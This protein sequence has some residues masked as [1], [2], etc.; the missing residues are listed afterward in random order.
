MRVSL[1]L[2]LLLGTHSIWALFS[3]P[4]QICY[5]WCV[6]VVIHSA[7]SNQYG[8]KSACFC[9][10][11]FHLFSSHLIFALSFAWFCS[12]FLCALDFLFCVTYAC[13]YACVC[14]CVC[15]DIPF[16]CPF[17]RVE[18]HFQHSF[19]HFLCP[20]NFIEL[21]Y[22]HEFDP[23]CCLRTK[24]VY[25]IWNAFARETSSLFVFHALRTE[26]NSTV[27]KFY[28]FKKKKKRFFLIFLWTKCIAILIISWNLSENMLKFQWS[29]SCEWDKN[30]PYWMFGVTVV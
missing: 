19:Y 11:Q 26:T 3:A 25:F 23:K 1:G 28:F 8:V 13:L 7:R 2:V 22:F 21:V 15:I 9:L 4:K 14:V 30:K 20:L 12:N 29:N 17:S 24:F 5:K 6:R 18:L 27:S 16:F 10:F